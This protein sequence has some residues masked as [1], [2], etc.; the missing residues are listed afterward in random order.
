[1]SRFLLVAVWM[2]PACQS[3]S[4]S[5]PAM[6][7]LTKPDVET[8]WTG[9]GDSQEDSRIETGDSGVSGGTDSGFP[10]TV[11]RVDCSRI[12]AANPT[13]EVCETGI[14]ECAGVFGDGAGCDAYCAAAGLICKA[15]FGGEPGCNKE[16]QNVLQCGDN[17]GHTSDWCVCGP[18]DGTESDP[19]PGCPVDSSN[20]P[21]FRELGYRSA[22][23]GQRHNWVLDCRDYAYS[24]AGAEHRECDSAYAPDGSRQGTASFVFENVPRGWYTAYVGGRHTENRNPSGAR[25]LV[26]GHAATIN[27]RS[28]SGSAVWDLH[29]Q[30]CLEGRV[31][32]VL[33]S[34]V[35]SG[36]D[37]VMGVRLDPVR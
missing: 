14:E 13:W 33:D 19:D 11:E 23:Y 32:V 6:P 8:G 20:P 4:S 29:G 5:N 17:N 37:S 1:V 3:P 25:F 22:S 27:Q 10:E 2:V 7:P 24:A 36:S 26:D 15:R 28:S 31:E 34:T 9:G 30:Y 35:N 21:V 12:S 18:S 16:P